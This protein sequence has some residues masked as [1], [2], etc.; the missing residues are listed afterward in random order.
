[1][2]A[3]FNLQGLDGKF[4]SHYKGAGEAAFN[5]QKSQIQRELDRFVLG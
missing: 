2:F 5:K 4:L 1:M 3:G